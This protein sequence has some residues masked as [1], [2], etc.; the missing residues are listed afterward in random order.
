LGADDVNVNILRAKSDQ[1]GRC[2]TEPASQ[3]GCA[4]SSP[5]RDICPESATDRVFES[6]GESAAHHGSGWKREFSSRVRVNERSTTGVAIS[7]HPR[8]GLL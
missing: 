2:K 1:A 4:T 5:S 6:R 8:F 3:I 7:R